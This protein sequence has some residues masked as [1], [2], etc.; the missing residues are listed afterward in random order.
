MLFSK[1]K[2]ARSLAG[3]RPCPGDTLILGTQIHSPPTP[4]RIR[5]SVVQGAALQAPELEARQYSLQAQSHHWVSFPLV[6]VLER[7]LLH[8]EFKEPKYLYP[9]K[10]PLRAGGGSSSYH[11][12]LQTNGAP[13]S[14]TD[15]YMIKEPALAHPQFINQPNGRPTSLSRPRRGGGVLTPRDPGD[16]ARMRHHK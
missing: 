2:H 15:I 8:H 1:Q 6:P 12:K 7:D 13:A 11:G 10:T 16:R 5:V 3:L 14:G 9:A 4:P